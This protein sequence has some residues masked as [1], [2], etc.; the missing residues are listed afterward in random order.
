MNKTEYTREEKEFIAKWGVP[1]DEQYDTSIVAFLPE[2]KIRVNSLMLAKMRA[3]AVANAEK[4]KKS[5]D[6]NY[7]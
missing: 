2:T 1:H 4:R 5:N 6:R 7:I 3:E